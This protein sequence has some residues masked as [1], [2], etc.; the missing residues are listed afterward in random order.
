MYSI[1]L[2]GAVPL[3]E[4]VY[5]KIVELVMGKV[6]IPGDQIPSVRNLAKEIGVNP[7]T[8]SKA[9]NLL[10]SDNI[11]YSLAGRGSFICEINS[12]KIQKEVLLKLD[13][14]IKEAKIAGLSKEGLVEKINER[15]ECIE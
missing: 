1:D 15:W 7:N 2:Q 10:E 4:Q 8:V 5:K 9:Y 12:D 11:I 13:E 14:C 6:L 3:Y